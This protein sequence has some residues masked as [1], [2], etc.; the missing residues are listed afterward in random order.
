[1]SSYHRTTRECPVRQLHPEVFRALRNY[2]Q[3]QKLGDLEAEAVTCCETISTRKNVNDLFSRFNSTE[4]ATVHMGMLLTSQ[5]LIWVRCGDTS[6]VSLSAADLTNIIVSTY[7]SM[8]VDDTGLEIIGYVEGSNRA[9][10]GY[11]GMG[12]EPAAQKFCDEVRQAITRI[13]P[14]KESIWPKWLGG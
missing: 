8:F 4:D 14:P 13:N 1:M 7:K 10:K 11:I 2:F 5:R 6:G 12:P 9:I 3:E